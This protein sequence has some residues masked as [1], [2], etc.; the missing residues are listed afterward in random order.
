M[1]TYLSAMLAIA[2]TVTAK[3]T[4]VSFAFPSQTTSSCAYIKIFFIK[5]WSLYIYF[6]NTNLR[7]LSY[8]LKT[9][10]EAHK[11]NCC[12]FNSLIFSH[13]LCVSVRLVFRQA[14]KLSQIVKI[15]AW[16]P[17]TRALCDTLRIRLGIPL[18]G[19]VFAAA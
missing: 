6:N 14:T 7:D 19:K 2:V 4:A 15:F 11:K 8:A 9:S 12:I 13:F 10:S 1:L 16:N 5:L 17:Q 18:N 3:L